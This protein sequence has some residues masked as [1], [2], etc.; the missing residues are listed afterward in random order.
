MECAARCVFASGVSGKS[1]VPLREGMQVL[2]FV[3]GPDSDVSGVVESLASRLEER[4]RVAIVSAGTVEHERTTVRL[5]AGG[6]QVTGAGRELGE[7]LD[8]LARNHEYALVVGFPDARLPTVAVGD[9]DVADPVVAAG[10]VDA[11]DESTLV[12]ELDSGDSHESLESLVAAV[13]DTD[14]AEFAGA[15]ATFTG[16]VRAKEYEDDDPTTSLTFEKY[17]GVAADRLAAL[18]EE[19]EAREGVLEVRLHHRTGRIPYGEDI[20]FV[21][22]L[23]GHRREAFETVSDG[24]DRLKE[25]VPIFKKEVTVGDEFWVHDRPE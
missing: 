3:A 22:V 18:R 15:I 7:V 12:A 13:K 4:G 14:A 1:S 25:E 5:D 2:G 6:Y 8:D 9:V 21:V 23:A 16:R 19:L 24:I 17:D 10:T 11:L 20:V